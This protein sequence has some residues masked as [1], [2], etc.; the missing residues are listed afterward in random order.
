[1]SPPGCQKMSAKPCSQNAEESCPVL[2]L[3]S[4]EQKPPNS[5]LI[6]DKD[7]LQSSPEVPVPLVQALAE[8]SEDTLQQGLA[9]LQAAEFL[10][11]T[12]LVPERAF[13]FKHALTQEVAYGSLLQE[14][15]R[16]LHARIVEALE[17]LAGERRGEQVAHL[18]LHALRGEVWD[19]A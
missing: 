19:K 5:L 8:W 2:S 14:R 3:Q 11:E 9:H 18:A 6:Q 4:R 12:R 7:V 10:Y 13:T 1:M 15:R 17:A 16:A